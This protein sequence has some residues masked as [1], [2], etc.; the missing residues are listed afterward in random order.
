MDNQSLMLTIPEVAKML[1][2]GKVKAYELARQGVIPS[3]RLGRAVRVP[4]QA[5]LNWLQQKVGV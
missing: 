2:I 1:K 5:F 4:R 3:I